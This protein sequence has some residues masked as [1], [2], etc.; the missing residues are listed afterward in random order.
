MPVPAEGWPFFDFD[1]IY[2]AGYIGQWY[3][4]PNEPTIGNSCNPEMSLTPKVMWHNQEFRAGSMQ[5]GLGKLIQT[6]KAQ[7]YEDHGCHL[8]I[9]SPV[10]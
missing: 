4:Q 6:N 1:T 9:Q 8:A 3:P 2:A 7:W 10:Q 5:N